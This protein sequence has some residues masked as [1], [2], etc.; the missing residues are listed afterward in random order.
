MG[1]R[2]DSI[3]VGES[4]TATFHGSK[5]LGNEPY[6]LEVVVAGRS[7][8]GDDRRVTLDDDGASFEVYRFNGHWAYGTSAERLSIA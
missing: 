1:K 6:T 4:V 8:T 5:N 7:G 3:A 2:L